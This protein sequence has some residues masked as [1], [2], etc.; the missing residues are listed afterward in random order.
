[1]ESINS[2]YL[3]KGVCCVV[4]K[5]GLSKYP[6]NTDEQTRRVECSSFTDEIELYKIDIII[7]GLYPDCDE[8]SVRADDLQPY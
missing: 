6:I 4:R 1:M 3:K 8:G 7:T 2:K 5:C